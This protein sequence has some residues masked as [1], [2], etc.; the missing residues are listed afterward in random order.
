[1]ARPWNGEKYMQVDSIAFTHNV[2]T[3][4]MFDEYLK[5]VRTDSINMVFV[6]PPIYIGATDKMTNLDDMYSVYH[7]FADKYDI[8]ILDYTYMNICYDTTYFYNAMHLNRL[9]AEIFSDR[10]ANDIKRLGIL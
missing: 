5:R 8:P 2:T 1:M 9:G 10:L 7:Q 6:Y 3:A 4:M